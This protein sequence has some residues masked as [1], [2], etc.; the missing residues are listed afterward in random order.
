M[1]ID[2]TRCVDEKTTFSS[3]L[4]GRVRGQ[5]AVGDG[6]QQNKESIDFFLFLTIVNREGKTI[7]F[8]RRISKHV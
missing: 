8:K 1:Q 5:R 2:W 6:L 3:S 4:R 7:H